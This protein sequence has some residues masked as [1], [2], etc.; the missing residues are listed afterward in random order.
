[1]SG[2]SGEDKEERRT[3]RRLNRL[4]FLDAPTVAILYHHHLLPSL[5]HP[6]PIPGLYKIDQLPKTMQKGRL[7]GSHRFSATVH[8]ERR[9][10]RVGKERD[11][12]EGVGERGQKTDLDVD[13]MIRQCRRQRSQD[14]RRC[15]SYRQMTVQSTY[16][17]NLGGFAEECRSHSASEGKGLGTAAVEPHAR[18]VVSH[19][20]G[21]LGCELRRGGSELKDEKRSLERMTFKDGATLFDEFNGPRAR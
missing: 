4:G 18:Y 19:K 11:K 20:P 5:R 17:V 13:R 15:I 14:L 1:M 21:R 6:L 16:R 12:R 10:A 8:C 2:C 3:S 7:G 9:D